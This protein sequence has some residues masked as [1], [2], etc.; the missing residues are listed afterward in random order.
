MDYTILQAAVTPLLQQLQAA[1]KEFAAKDAAANRSEMI[2][3]QK[4]AEADA[5]AQKI[6]DL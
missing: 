5:S 3:A 1:E 2:A 4:R 6:T